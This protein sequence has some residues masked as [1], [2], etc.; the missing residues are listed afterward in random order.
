MKDKRVSS[1]RAD[2]RYF[3]CASVL[4][5]I[6][7]FSGCLRSSD[8]MGRYQG[9]QTDPHGTTQVVA[10]IPGMI[11]VDHSKVI[12]FKI[13]PISGS[14]TGDEY[15]ISI[16]KD[17]ILLLAPKISADEID[18]VRVGH[19]A[20]GTL[21]PQNDQRQVRI[22]WSPGKVDLNVT[23]RNN[24]LFSI[25]LLRDDSLPP[26]TTRVGLGNTYTLDE[27]MGRA[28]FLNYSV[29]QEAERVYRAK[30]NIAVTRGNLLPK[31]SARS[32][33]SIAG[34]AI[35]GGTSLVGGDFLTVVGDALPFI[36][37]SNWFQFKTSKDVFQA[38]R[39]SFA[40]LRGN[41]MSAVEG[42][43]YL[44]YRDQAVLAQLDRQIDWMTRTQA[45]LRQEEKVGTLPNGSADFFGISIAQMERDRIAFDTLIK[46]EY[47]Q[48]SQAVALPPLNG[49]S[50]LTPLNVPDLEAIQPLQAEDFFRDAQEK[51]YELKAFKFL[52]DAAQYQKKDVFFQFLNPDGNGSIGFGTAA[53]FRI[54]KSK[55]NELLKKRDETFGLIEQ[56]SGQVANEF[57]AALKNY[58]V[59]QDG[60]ASTERRIEW[61]RL[62]HISGDQTLNEGDFISDLIALQFKLLEL[63]ADRL[64]SIYGLMMSRAKLDRLLLDGFYKGLEDCMP[65]DK[66][67]LMEYELNHL[68]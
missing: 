15:R 18:L 27:L 49:V 19:C 4:F 13:F 21:L 9:E 36:F 8:F 60:I 32:L 67:S 51:S 45:T 55:E 37:P 22:C 39:M 46:S 33:V 14:A 58:A 30:E 7:V 48:L 5:S 57:N 56:K 61:L 29:A 1:S 41:E 38:E 34:A 54:A 31:L 63:N 52:L 50:G 23:F 62:R 12:R 11:R 17:R 25:H 16:S 66:G 35:S 59:S 6:S 64:S 2:F 24:I 3:I 65:E 40:S 44:I 53:S 10:Q 28:R 26:P 43:F 47:L 68:R 20:T 42:L